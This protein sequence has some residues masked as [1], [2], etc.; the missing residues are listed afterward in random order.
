[1]ARSDGFE[2]PMGAAMSAIFA[3]VLG[4]PGA[5]LALLG[6]GSGSW[7]NGVNWLG[8]GFLGV[9]G[10]FLLGGLFRALQGLRRKGPDAD[11]LPEGPPPPLDLPAVRVRLARSARPARRQA[12]AD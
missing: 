6:A 5:V 4:L 10:L 2:R 12:A 9:A 1:M 7:P 11:E 8:L 3:V